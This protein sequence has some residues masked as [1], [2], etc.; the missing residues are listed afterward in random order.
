[1]RI[2]KLPQ[3]VI[4]EAYKGDVQVLFEVNKKGEFKVIYLDAIYDELKE[5]SKRVFELLPNVKPATYN[6]KPTFVQYSI[7]I[8]IPLIEPVRELDKPTETQLT[9]KDKLNA[10]LS[11]EYDAVND[12]LKPYEKLEYTSELNIPFTHT[13]YARFDDEMNALG[14]NSH[15]GAKP[16]I[17]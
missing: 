4:D 12:E 16:F 10:T 9:E 15:T 17:V 3:I 8:A 5:E 13:Y 14:T 6:G 2:L 11:N 1:M 7:G